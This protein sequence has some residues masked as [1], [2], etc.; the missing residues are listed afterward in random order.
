M[1]AAKDK[2]EKTFAF[3]FLKLMKEDGSIVCDGQHELYVYK[4]GVV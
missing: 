4:V 1:S 2:A 3:S